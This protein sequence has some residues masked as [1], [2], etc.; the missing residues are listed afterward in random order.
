MTTLAHLRPNDKA[1]IEG[2]FGEEDL[3][4]RLL[5]MGMIQGETVEYLRK[6]PLGDPMIFR[7]GGTR[8]SLRHAD[9]A[10]VQVSVLE[11]VT[12]S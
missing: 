6:A 12:V 8:L 2:L 5:C 11:D 4:Q 1:R 3:V 10:R 7:V 9:A